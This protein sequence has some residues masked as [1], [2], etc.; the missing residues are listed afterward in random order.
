MNLAKK[1]LSIKNRNLKLNTKLAVAQEAPI[2]T[3]MKIFQWSRALLV[4]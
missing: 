2:Q 1:K 3:L 4:P